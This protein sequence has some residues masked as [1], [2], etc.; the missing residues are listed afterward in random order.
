MENNL[1]ELRD[2]HLPAESISIWPLA[3]GWWFMVTVITVAVV[4]VLLYRLWRRKSKKLY[5]LNL[6]SKLDGKTPV[7]AIELSEILR[8]ICIYKYPQASSLLGEKW[9]AFLNTRS[10]M[11]LEGDAARLLIDAPYINPQTSVYNPAV[12]EKLRMFCRSWIGENL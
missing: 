6:L 4:C 9:I 5:A 2:I 1:P 8:R 3:W 10:K 12:F 7:S 11:K